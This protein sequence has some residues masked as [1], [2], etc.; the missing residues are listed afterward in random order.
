[1]TVHLS[2]EITRLKKM[3]LQLCAVVEDRF[4]KA[5]AAVQ[6]RNASLADSVIAD[7]KTIDHMEVEVEEECLKILALHQPVAIDLRYVVAVLKMNNDLERIGDLAV[8]ISEQAA[9]LARCEQMAVGFDFNTMAQKVRIMLQ[10]SIEALVNMTP[11]LAREV[12][13]SD[14]EID[15]MNR[16]MYALIYKAVQGQ[17]QCLPILLRYL[18]VSRYLER[19]ADYTTNIAEDVIYMIEGQIVRHRNGISA[20]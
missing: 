10:K 18:S 4:Q 6:E 8:N 17:P 12:L 14:D 3:I 5:V 13:I 11:P 20:A 2:K 16:E 15:N 1:M 7:D 19:I 9:E